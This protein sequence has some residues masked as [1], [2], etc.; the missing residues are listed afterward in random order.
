VVYDPAG[1][2][3]PGVQ[4]GA[5]AGTGGQTAVWNELHK[6]WIGLSEGDYLNVSNP[7]DIYPI[8]KAVFEATYE[9]VK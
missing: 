7:G 9:V 1:T 4:I 3:H 8:S 2:A 6:S 5:G